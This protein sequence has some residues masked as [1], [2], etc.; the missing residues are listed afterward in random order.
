LP[1]NSGWRAGVAALVVTGT[2]H[3][4]RGDAPRASG[5]A[6]GARVQ[7][8]ADSIHRYQG[9]GA[10]R[11]DGA[12]YLVRVLQQLR[13]QPAGDKDRF[14]QQVPI[15]QRQLDS[16]ASRVV[17]QQYALKPGIDFVPLVGRRWNAIPLRGQG[18]DTARF[19]GRLGDPS[20]RPESLASRTVVLRV[21]LDARGQPD[22]RIWNHADDLRKYNHSAGLLIEAL[23]LMPRHVLQTLYDPEFTLPDTTP[24]KEIP[25]I[26][27]ISRSALGQFEYDLARPGKRLINMSFDVRQRSVS[28]P[29]RNVLAYVNGSDRTLAKDLIVV[30]AR[31]N[32][33]RAGDQALS[34]AQDSAQVDASAMLL[35]LAEEVTRGAPPRRS[36]LFVWTIGTE[37]TPLGAEWF[38][39]HPTFPTTPGYVAALHLAA[40]AAAQ[41]RASSVVQIV[42]GDGRTSRIV[43]ALDSLLRVGD[44]GLKVDLETPVTP[45]E[46]C[47]GDQIPFVAKD[48][49]SVFVWHNLPGTALGAAVRYAANGRIVRLVAD[50]LADIANRTA[51]PGMLTGE[52]E[53]IICP[54]REIR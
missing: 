24:R 5:D 32:T 34:S 1:F 48:V 29:A 46:V 2:V 49:P 8:F 50:G 25:P 36:I 47:A 23:D 28:G 31:L 7:A 6:L 45:T 3:A 35:A 53:K 51:R 20:V 37:T 40:G 16:A 54:I 9:R 11:A 13:L 22:Y 27:L 41:R 14:I 17:F 12:D 18:S 42:P 4:Q 38:I 33:L 15:V 10:S 39:D 43:T 26:I 52:T 44:Y 30:S 19:G 21:P